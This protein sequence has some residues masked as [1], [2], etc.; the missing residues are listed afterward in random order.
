[1]NSTIQSL[2][3][4]PEPDERG[5]I[6][7]LWGC[8]ATIL[9]CSWSAVHSNIPPD[10]E[11]QWRLYWRKFKYMMM[12]IIAPELVTTIALDEFVAMRRWRRRV[13]K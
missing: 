8:S 2:G 3:F 13:W 12:G 10:N 5:T 11:S 4:V 1:M 6:S 7:L 9:I